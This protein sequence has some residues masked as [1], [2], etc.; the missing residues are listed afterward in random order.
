MA[1]ARATAKTQFRAYG[2]GA[3]G[4]YTDSPY[5]AGVLSSLGYRIEYGWAVPLEPYVANELYN[6]GVPS[7]GSRAMI[8][9]PDNYLYRASLDVT[10]SLP[11]PG[12]WSLDIFEVV[13]WQMSGATV[14]GSLALARAPF[15]TFDVPEGTN[16]DAPFQTDLHVEDAGVVQLDGD[17]DLT[18]PCF[19]QGMVTI[20]APG[21]PVM[22]NG[23]EAT[24]LTV[25]YGAVTIKPMSAPGPAPPAGTVQIGTRRSGLRDGKRT[26]AGR[27]VGVPVVAAPSFGGGGG[28]Y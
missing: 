7:L 11:E 20:R 26:V 9:T 10:L 28:N 6:E 17:F 15:Q 5:Q 14:I 2:A 16:H 22:V 21:Y 24:I 18:T 27:A 25:N 23:D 1:A 3:D 8:E 12:T 4:F 13:L 19:V